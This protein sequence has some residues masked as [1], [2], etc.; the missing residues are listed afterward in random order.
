MS[1]APFVPPPGDHP[2]DRLGRLFLRAFSVMDVAEPLPSFDAG[3]PA[4]EVEAFLRSR[5][6]ALVGVRED[7]LVAGFAE[8]DDL[9]DGRLS[10]HVRRFGP[11]DLVP[12]T[13]SLSE[14]I[15]SLDVN[16]RCFVSVLGRVG[17]NV[18]FRDLEK[19]PVRM[20]LFGMITIFEMFVTGRIRDRLPGDAW[21]RHVSPA[22]LARARALQEERR[23]RGRDADLLECVQLA[24]KAAVLVRAPGVAP[25][26]DLGSRR[27]A[28]EAY[29][30]IQ[31]LRNALA[32]TQREIV[33]TD[34][35]L[36]VRMADRVEQIAALA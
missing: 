6:L 9:R 25:E 20:W 26:L 36:V 32:H 31:A 28:E 34:W 5:G 13:A 8:R 7:G 23:R 16:G 30:R 1:D 29:Q 15:R 22:R 17:A 24:D 12:S 21:V 11:D 4:A 33:S 27:Q 35:Q 19:P 14:T 18:T 2:G 10:D 3:A